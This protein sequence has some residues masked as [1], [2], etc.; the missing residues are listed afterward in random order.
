MNTDVGTNSET[1]GETG[2]RKYIVRQ[3]HRKS[4]QRERKMYGQRDRQIDRQKT[5][6]AEQSRYDSPIF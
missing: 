3:T 2:R 5:N 4:R 6:R 1:D